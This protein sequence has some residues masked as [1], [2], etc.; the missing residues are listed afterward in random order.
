M[1]CAACSPGWCAGVWA[2]AGIWLPCWSGLPT[3]NLNFGITDPALISF[4]ALFLLTHAFLEEVAFRGL[5]M[6]AFVNRWGSTTGGLVKSVLVSS[7][8]FASY[9]LANILGGNPL[10][11]V[12][13]Q[14]VG[15][16]FLGILFGALML[17]GK[18]IYPVAFLHGLVNFAASLNLSANASDGT[19]PAAWLLQTALLVPLALL[20]LY[21]LRNQ[22]QRSVV[23]DGGPEMTTI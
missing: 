9:H 5:I 19:D 14:M 17:S 1:G 12:L 2:C 18:S 6:V 7:L 15:A 16:F 20:S 10:P 11:V 23:P 13:L 4:V 22:L 8:F 21:I 3:G